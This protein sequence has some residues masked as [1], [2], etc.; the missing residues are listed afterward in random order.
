MHNAATRKETACS[1]AQL[2]RRI[3]SA[4]TNY[5][6]YCCYYYYYYLLSLSRHI[7]SS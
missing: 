5:Y 3:Y 6:Y 2:V 4:T 7:L 1:V